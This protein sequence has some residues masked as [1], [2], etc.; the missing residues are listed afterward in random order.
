MATTSRPQAQSDTEHELARL[1]SQ[2]REMMASES[3]LPP[4]DGG[5]QANITLLACCIIQL[6]VWGKNHAVF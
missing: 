1:P 6:P 4:A 5:R 3:Q 2:D